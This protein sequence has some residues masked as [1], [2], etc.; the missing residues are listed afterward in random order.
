ML[1]NKHYNVA[2]THAFLSASQNAWT[3]YD[4]E[5]LEMMFT[6][7]MAARRGTELHALA[8]DLIRLGVK[9]P[10][11]SATLNQ[12]VNDA[13]GYRMKSEQTLFY[14]ENCYGTADSCAFRKEKGFDKPVFRVHDLKTG[15][16]EAS[17]RQLEVYCALFCL[18]Y[19]Q[20]PFDIVMILRIYQNDTFKEMIAEPD[21]I[22]R[23][24][25]QIK[26]FNKRIVAMKTDAEIL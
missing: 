23:I 21:Q 22:I 17:F 14:S 24:M 18:E 5:K 1:W 7:A 6:Q 12:Y 20:S 4:E 16:I 10:R 15:L 9:L 26:I 8:H 13:I 11:T 25:E 19:H 3:N 2:G